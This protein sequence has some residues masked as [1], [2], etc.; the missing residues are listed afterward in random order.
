MK[1]ISTLFAFLLIIASMFI[2]ANVISFSTGAPNNAAGSPSH[3]STTCAMCHTGT[4]NQRLNWI[5]SAEL[6][7]GYEPGVQYNMK[8]RAENT[9]TSK[10]G[11][12][13]T[14]ETNDG[15]KAG[16]PVV[17]DAARTKIVNTHYITHTSAGTSGQD[18]AVWLFKWDAPANPM[19]IVTFYGA[20][21]GANGNNQNTGDIVYVSTTDVFLH[22]TQGV[23]TSGSVNGS[24]M[25]TYPNPADVEVNL[26][27]ET[28]V[29]DPLLRIFD[30]S[31]RLLR[32][33]SWDYTNQMKVDV[34]SLPN[35]T[36]LLQMVL[37]NDF[38]NTKLL[39]RHQ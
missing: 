30:V 9:G 20:F 4:V 11:F 2:A 35:G 23:A 39:V 22:G 28:A 33:I 15:T 6:S 3:N 29:A 21:I 1:N 10:F 16:V 38:I 31:G 24:R 32:E 36:Y 26:R 18:S 37:E 17:T 13:V 19:G 25:F 34:S 8:A 14:I 7:Q 5:T 12:I 27:L